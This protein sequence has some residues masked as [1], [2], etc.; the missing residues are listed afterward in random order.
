MLDFLSIGTGTRDVFIKSQLFK[1]V[2]DPEH[3]EK[4]GFTTGEAQ[5]FAFGGKLDIGEPKFCIGG[6]AANA[7]VTFARQGWQTGALLRL[8]EDENGEAILKTLKKEKIKTVPIFSKDK[9]TAFSVVMVS[10]SG[11]RTILTYRGAG[12]EWPKSEIPFKKI[13][14]RWAYIVP[15][16]IS[17]STIS[18]I[19]AHLKS[20]GAKI[21]MNPSRFY[22]EM[23]PKQLKP[24]LSRLDAVIL[25]REEASLLT[26]VPYEQEEKIFRRL[27]ELVDGIAIM[28]DGP[29]GVSVSDGEVIYRAG[30][31]KE[32]KIVDRTGAGDAFGSAFISALAEYEK[33]NRL[34]NKTFPPQAIEYAIRLASANATSV[35]EYVGAQEGILT[36]KEFEK[37]RRWKKIN[38]ESKKI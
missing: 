26:N 34:P 17:F 16:K 29:K 5:C 14:A 1:V 12:E 7:A 35:V 28:T 27:D 4:L 32:K 30:V 10:P 31:F 11:E 38:I 15:S 19:V 22:I 37:N 24:I 9:G 13:S 33:K 20:Q 6:G 21:A 23:G 3:L 18:L 2:R 36:K 8:G 25:N